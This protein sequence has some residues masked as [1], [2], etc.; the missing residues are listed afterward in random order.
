MRLDYFMPVYD[1]CSR[2]QR[3]VK[4]SVKD[5]FAALMA[6][7]LAESR[8][9]RLLMRLRGYGRRHLEGSSA[10]SENLRRSRFTQLVVAPKEEVVYGLVGRFWKLR[11]DL[12]SL[13]SREEFLA[14]EQPGYAK[15][16]WNFSL[17]A[18][19]EQ[20]TRLCTE[21]RVLCLG[22][23]A[24]RRFRAYWFLVAPFSGLMR[25]SMLRA[26]ARRAEAHRVIPS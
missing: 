9:V 19:S 13:D 15:A 25:R 11:G 17:H 16:A 20:L 12:V 1:V 26:I 3:R 4:A 14:F 5:T 24:R 8:L 22:A 2:H 10:L 7:D 6:A 21:T 18:E 23:A